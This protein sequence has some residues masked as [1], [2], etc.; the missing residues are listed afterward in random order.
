MILV[1]EP[2]LPTVEGVDQGQEVI[3]SF[4]RVSYSWMRPSRIKWRNFLRRV[5][6]LCD[7]HESKT[8]AFCFFDSGNNKNTAV[9]SSLRSRQE[10][11]QSLN[12]VDKMENEDIALTATTDK[13]NTDREGDA[14]A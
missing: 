12:V 4:I 3:M 9:H 5:D 10:Q 7:E 14:R 13:R 8:P 6:N 11:G 1:S 2:I